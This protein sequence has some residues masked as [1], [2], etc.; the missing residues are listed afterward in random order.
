MFFGSIPA[1]VTPFSDRSVDEDSFSAFVEWQIDQGS[2]G[3][4]PCG[5]TGEVATLNADEHRKVIATA[6]VAELERSE[7]PWIHAYFQGPRGR[8][9]Q[10]AQGGREATD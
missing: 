8:A 3:L 5:T 4:V 2:N 10:V 6:P 1:L 9:A 7:H